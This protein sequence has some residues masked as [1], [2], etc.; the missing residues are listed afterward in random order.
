MERSDEVGVGPHPRPW[1][2]DPRLDP[3]LLAEGDRRN[4]VDRYRYWRNEAIVADLD[5]PA[6]PVP[7]R[8]R[9]LAARPQHRHGRA[10]RQRVPRGRGAHRRPPAVEPARCHGHRP[11]PA[12]A[13]PPDDRRAAWRGPAA[14]ASR[15]SAST[16]CPVPCRSR[17]SSCPS[18]AS[19]C[20]ARRAPG[21]SADA[22]APP[23]EVV[24][25]IAQFGSTRSINAGV[26]SGIAMHAWI[27]RHAAADPAPRLKSV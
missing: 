17:R 13:T 20:S 21:S 3:A 4:V 14:R 22:R 15:S 10:Q 12:P 24:C 11:V 5:A 8:H 9:E 23:C 19:C 27:R 25:S 6:T 26:A 1:P 7:R 18:G 2:D 16:S